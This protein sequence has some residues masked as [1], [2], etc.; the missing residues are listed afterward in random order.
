MEEW[1]QN[2]HLLGLGSLLS[3]SDFDSD[4]SE[5]S[6]DSGYEERADWLE[7]W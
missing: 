4:I 1:Y 7:L 3:L 6:R 2:L 5:E